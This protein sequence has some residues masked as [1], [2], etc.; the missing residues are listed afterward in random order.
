MAK[1]T[2]KV[3]IQYE[4]EGENQAIGS[5]RRVKREAQNT[6][7]GTGASGQIQDAIRNAFG[8]IGAN[9]GGELGG[10]DEA[11]RKA[12]EGVGEVA[13]SLAGGGVSAA[14]L[15]TA[16]AIALP[17]I[18]ATALAVKNFTDTIYANEQAIQSAI[19]AQDTYYKA[20]ANSTTEEATATLEQSQRDLQ[21]TRD[22]IANLQNAADTA[23]ESGL[24]SFIG[25]LGS[26]IAFA[27]GPG[28]E[29]LDQ[30]DKLK[31][32]ESD[33]AADTAALERAIASGALAATDARIAEEKLADAREK[34]AEGRI[35]RE[36]SLLQRANSFT[37]ESITERQ[38]EIEG[39]Q[40]LL[41]AR[42]NQGGLTDL[43]IQKINEAIAALQEESETL[44]D[45][46]LAIA[47]ANDAEKLRQE[48]LKDTAKTVMDYNEDVE[49]LTT[50]HAEQ[51][52]D[53]EK[54][55]QDKLVSLAEEAADAT[56]RAVESLVEARD[57][58]QLSLNRATEDA[59]ARARSD[60]LDAQIAFYRDEAQAAREHADDIIKIREDAADKE[61]DLIAGRD[62]AGLFRLRRDTNKQIIDTQRGYSKEREERLIALQQDREDRQRH[63]IEEAIQRQVN[64]Q[65]Q[66]DDANTQYNKQIALVSR[67]LQTETALA[68]RAARYE[69]ALENS[70]YNTKIGMLQTAVQTELNLLSQGLS[71]RLQLIQREQD[72]LNQAAAY[73]AGIFGNTGFTFPFG[74]VTNNRNASVSNTF[75]IKGNNPQALGEYIKGQVGLGIKGI[76]G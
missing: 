17:A 45:T 38:R 24:G 62:F 1:H 64:Y 43:E 59:T 75:N 69:V 55:K 12:G 4:T 21:A 76:F 15:A 2:E 33:L 20:I 56:A 10:L 54:K 19:K 25:D 58:A 44:D 18:I 14:S 39:L 3:V 42:K 61:A 31:E 9:L 70:K 23:Y 60:E 68:E 72:A 29:V 22:E 37:E 53:I 40:D 66:I 36:L 41:V 35:A 65:R 52:A 6:E 46:I 63:Y 74:S 57:K 11:G 73:R 50:E 13:A 30:I 7:T 34:F 8:D 27:L 67:K 47:Q 51:L 5:L 32:K 26:K 28:K 48:I 71:F 16:A 49:K